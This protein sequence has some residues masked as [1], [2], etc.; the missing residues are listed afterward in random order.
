MSV[1]A[2][3]FLKKGLNILL[4]YKFGF[5]VV[6]THQASDTTPHI[7]SHVPFV[8]WPENFFIVCHYFMWA[9]FR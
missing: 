8:E 7:Y 3:R 5:K 2:A 6:K 4:T 1:L 9:E